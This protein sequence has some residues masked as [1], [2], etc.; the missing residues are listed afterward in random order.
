MHRLPLL[1]PLLTIVL[2]LGCVDGAGPGNDP[3]EPDNPNDAQHAPV[4]VS[5]SAQTS[6]RFGDDLRLEVSGNDADGDAAGLSVRLLAG[7]N[8][9]AP[10]F[11]SDLDGFPDSGQTYL[12]FDAPVA[13]STDSFD[14]AAT[15][16][17]LFDQGLEVSSVELA[18]VDGEGRLSAVIAGPVA[19]QPVKQFSEA[20]DPSFVRDRC[21]DDLGC[22]GAP[23]TCQP[24][25]APAILQMAYFEPADPAVD[26][27]RLLVAGTEPDDDLRF[28]HLELMDEAGNPVSIDL[29]GDD[30]PDGSTFDVDASASGSSGRFFV[31]LKLGPGTQELIK[32]IAAVP[33]DRGGRTGLR[34]EATLAPIVVKTAG[35]VCDP[36]G[37]DTCVTDA[38][39]VT[40]VNG[41]S[42]CQAES[43][44]RAQQCAQAEVLTLNEGHASH[45][46]IVDGASVWDAPPGCSTNDPRGRPEAVV[47]L[48]LNQDANR[49]VITTDTPNTNFDTTVYVMSTCSNVGS[50]AV[51]CGDDGAQTVASTV[52]MQAVPA[53][54]YAVI[55]DSFSPAGGAFGLEVIVE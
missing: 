13:A 53:G 30:S 25:E 8:A 52:E 40:A 33:E 3:D 21:A 19:A 9:E 4:L 45:L 51:A 20:C 48:R 41:T 39:C 10:L 42:T 49:V 1:T 50:L 12:P 16:L 47:L 5:A 27:P 22:K 55:I 44:A 43:A 7:N 15:L 28:L 46:G 11:D 31:E 36:S 26:G 29:D 18:L 34:L 35:Q 23:A 38:A 37:F 17:G 14:A 6:G 24:G 54:T 2:A 32:R